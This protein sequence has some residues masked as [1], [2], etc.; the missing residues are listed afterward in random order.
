L[1]N[2]D[3]GQWHCDFCSESQDE[4]ALLIAGPNGIAI[5]NRCICQCNEIILQAL[6]TQQVVKPFNQ[7]ESKS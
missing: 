2:K 3:T 5:C 4:V 6:K 7:Q 1:K